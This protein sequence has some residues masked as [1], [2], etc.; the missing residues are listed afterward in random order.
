MSESGAIEKHLNSAAKRVALGTL[1]NFRGGGLEVVC[2]DQSYLCGEAEAPLQGTVVVHDERFFRRMLA[3]GEVGIGEAY[4]DGDWSSPDPVTVVR[5]GLRNLERVEDENRLFSILRRWRD[6]AQHWLRANTPAGSRRNIGHHYDLSNEFFRVFLD[7]SM[8]YSCA[9]YQ[10]PGDSLALAQIHKFDLICRKLQLGPGDHLLE[11][12]T[13]WGGLAVH[14]AERYGCRVTTTT[15]SGEQHDFVQ[16]KLSRR[17]LLCGRAP[18]RVELLLE[19]YRQLKGRYDKIVSIEMFEAV[20]Y[21]RYDDYFRTCDRLL[22]RDGTMLLQTIT[23]PD[24]RFARYLGRCDWIQRY[25]FPGA[26]LASVGE[27]LRSLARATR[28]SLF[29]SEDIGL[30]YARTLGEWRRRFL[31]ALPR[32]RA[33]GF[34]ERF[35]RMWDYYLATCEASFLERNTGDFQL[36]LTANNNPRMLH[37]EPWREETFAAP[38]EFLRSRVCAD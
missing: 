36:L 9:Y 32:V 38:V 33:L 35:I 14:A 20:G 1:G 19:D 7:P 11:I 18:G 15:I 5:V 4:M 30:H 27:I 24:Q 34:D 12:G 6:L 3:G 25:I 26:E 23:V 2:P 37:G 13:G 29:H 10:T 8:A 21:R 31:E 22:E 28:L 17:G 16:E